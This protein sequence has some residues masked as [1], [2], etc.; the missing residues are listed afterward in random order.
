MYATKRPGG[1]LERGCQPARSCMRGDW[2][3]S[4]DAYFGTQKL[5]VQLHS[6]IWQGQAGGSHSM[7]TGKPA[8]AQP[9]AT[10]GLSSQEAGRVTSAIDPCGAKLGLNTHTGM[11][12]QHVG[13]SPHAHCKLLS[14]LSGGCSA[15]CWGLAHGKA[16]DKPRGYHSL[17][18]F[19]S[20]PPSM[21]S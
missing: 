5:G 20:P 13:V 1:M 14:Q 18:G 6:Y 11:L 4:G 2:V 12:A 9:Y 19:R 8:S 21:Q 3:L 7:Q 17:L 10:G 16:P 15:C